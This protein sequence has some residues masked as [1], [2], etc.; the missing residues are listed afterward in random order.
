MYR[1]TRII[2]N[3]YR[4][5]GSFASQIDFTPK[6]PKVNPPIKLITAAGVLDFFK[7]KEDPE[8]EESDLIITIKRGL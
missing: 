8:Q 1:F 7:K 2:F 4:R 5:L 6:F 3:N